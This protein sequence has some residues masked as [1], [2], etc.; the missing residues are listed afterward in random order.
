MLVLSPDVSPYPCV[1]NNFVTN[2]R[3]TH[4]HTH[5]QPFKIRY[6]S[7]A[8]QNKQALQSSCELLRQDGCQKLSLAF[9]S[10]DKLW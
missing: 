8:F 1:T 6:L 2:M 10:C 7:E 3:F 5:M 4:R 9:I